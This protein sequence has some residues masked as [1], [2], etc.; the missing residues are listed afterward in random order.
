VDGNSAQAEVALIRERGGQR[1]R[2]GTRDIGDH[3]QRCQAREKDLRVHLRAPADYGHVPQVVITASRSLTSTTQLGEM[4]AVQP[5][6]HGSGHAP[7]VVI[8]ASRSLTFT[9]PSGAPGGAI[10]AR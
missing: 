4:S 1:K 2:L 7:Q 5:G 6:G 10:S 9:R 3:A 8:T